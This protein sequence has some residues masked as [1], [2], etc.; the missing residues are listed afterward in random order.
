MLVCVYVCFSVCIKM[1]CVII[2]NMFW[3][4]NSDF[5]IICLFLSAVSGVFL[6][7]LMC[8]QLM[9]CC[10]CVLCSLCV[11]VRV[12]GLWPALDGH[13]GDVFFS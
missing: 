5:R 13:F 3:N 8:R 2:C 1:Y 11:C 10:V 9:M 12:R 7:S 4:A 6:F